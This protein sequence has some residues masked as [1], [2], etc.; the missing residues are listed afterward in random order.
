[1]VGLRKLHITLYIRWGDELDRYEELWKTHETELLN[2][3][4][5]VTAPR[6]FVLVL[7]DRRCSIDTD[8]GESTCILQ[9]PEELLADVEEV[10]EEFLQVTF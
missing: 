1:M 5:A 10:T 8:M 4:K 2:P 7:P 6:D 9:L 3:V